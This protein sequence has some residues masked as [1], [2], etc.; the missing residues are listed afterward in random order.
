MTVMMIMRMVIVAGCSFRRG[1]KIGLLVMVRF[2]DESKLCLR[3]D[4]GQ[5]PFVS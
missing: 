2:Q 5:L 1:M 4:F 3:N